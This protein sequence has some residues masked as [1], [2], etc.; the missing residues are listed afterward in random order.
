MEE[1]QHTAKPYLDAAAENM[2]H[3]RDGVVCLSEFLCFAKVKGYV[4]MSNPH[5]FRQLNTSCTGKLSFDEA[6]AFFYIV[7]SARPL[8]NRCER[9]VLGIFFT[10]VKCFDDAD[11]SGT[12]NLCTSCFSRGKYVHSHD[13]FLDNLVLLHDKRGELKEERNKFRQPAT[14]A[15]NCT[16]R[17]IVPANLGRAIFTARAFTMCVTLS[18]MTAL[19][20]L[21]CLSRAFAWLPLRSPLWTDMAAAEYRK[22]TNQRWSPCFGN[23]EVVVAPGAGG[24]DDHPMFCHFWVHPSW[25]RKPDLFSIEVVTAVKP[26]PPWRLLLEVTTTT[27]GGCLV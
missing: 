1:L 6:I 22:A 17:E 18:L 23:P 16:S 21:L 2:D 14:D 3:D 11:E 5:F 12:F 26:P 10:C 19:R 8:C 7:T 4:R 20:A 25:A 9:L 27:G 13:H 15:Y 24:N